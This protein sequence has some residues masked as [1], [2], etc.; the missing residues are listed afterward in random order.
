MKLRRW[1]RVRHRSPQS[2]SWTRGVLL[3]ETAK[4]ASRA[5]PLPAIELVEFG[6]L[7]HES[8]KMVSYAALFLQSSSWTWDVLPH[9]TVKKMA[10][11][12]A[13]LHAVE[14]MDQVSYFVE[15]R[16][17]LCVRHCSRSRA[18]GRRVPLRETVKMASRAS[19]LPAVELMDLG[20]LLHDTAALL[21]QSSSWTSVSYV[22]QLR[23]WL[24][25]RHCSP[26]SSS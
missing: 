15:L 9:E 21:L 20:V 22:M 6:V 25:V 23:R 2:S 7:L 1:L 13:L 24:R 12:A 4:M 26:Q 18:H 19:L 3:H 16:R 10:W 8:A 17:W 11:R 14:L 5:A